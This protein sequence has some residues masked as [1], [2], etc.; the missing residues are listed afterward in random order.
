MNNFNGK[1]VHNASFTRQ[2]PA[3][4]TFEHPCAYALAQFILD[5]CM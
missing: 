1:Q 5:T 3:Y 2:A 4:R